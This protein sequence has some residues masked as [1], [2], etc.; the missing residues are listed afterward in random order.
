MMDNNT[1]GN[2]EYGR[3]WKDVSPGYESTNGEDNGN[4][5]PERRPP[6]AVGAVYYLQ[7]DRFEE[8]T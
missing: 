1:P 4:S 2:V 5:S 6:R 3:F 8:T 7:H